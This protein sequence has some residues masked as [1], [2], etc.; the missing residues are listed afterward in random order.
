MFRHRCAVFRE[1]QN[2]EVLAQHI[3]VGIKT[4]VTNIFK[5]LKYIKKTDNCTNYSTVILK[6]YNSQQFHVEV[7]SCDVLSTRTNIRL[8]PCDLEWSRPGR[9]SRWCLSY[10][11]VHCHCT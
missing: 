2:K 4:A 10:L 11:P 3:S 1:L 7:C 8:D 6:L 5:L 9:A